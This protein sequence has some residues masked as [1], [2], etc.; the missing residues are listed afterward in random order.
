MKINV[1]DS[2]QE[3]NFVVLALKKMPVSCWWRARKIMLL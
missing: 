1:N 3:D 2:I